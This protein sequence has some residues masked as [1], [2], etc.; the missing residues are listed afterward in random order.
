M[1]KAAQVLSYE[2]E[3]T[4]EA[5][6][7]KIK[8]LEPKRRSYL[9]ST[10]ESFGISSL[11]LVSADTLYRFQHAAKRDFTFVPGAYRYYRASLETA[12]FF[13]AKEN[14]GDFFSMEQKSRNERFLFQ[15]MASFLASLGIRD[16]HGITGEVR[17]SYEKYIRNFY[18]EKLLEYTKYMDRI[19]IESIQASTFT[20]TPH[21]KDEIFY[22]AYYPNIA[23]SNYFY[24]TA[25]KEF[26]F[27]DFSLTVP[28]IL[29]QQI[30]S[31]LINIAENLDGKR[32]HY[33]IQHHITPLWYL[34]RYCI[35]KGIYNLLYITKNEVDDFPLYLKDKMDAISKSA[36]Q[37][38]HRT[39]KF[40]FM[41]TEKIDFESTAWFLERFSLDPARIN[42][43]RPIEAFYFDDIKNPSHRR[44]L[45]S[46]I[47]YLLVLSPKYSL[48]YILSK[49]YDIKHMLHYLDNHNISILG[50]N[51]S[52]LE[53]YIESIDTKDI[54]PE[55]F[56]DT[57]YSIHSFFRNITLRE[58]LTLPHFYFDYYYKKEVPHHNDRSVSEDDIDKILSVL[59]DFPE[60]L[61][62]MYL[63]LYSTG[64]RINEI[65]VIQSDALSISDDTYWLL[66]YQ[67]KMKTEKMIPIPEDLYILLTDYLGRREIDSIYL[68]PSIKD[69]NKPFNAGTFSKQMKQHLKENGITSDIDFR[70]HDYRHTIISDIYYSGAGIQ[71]AREF[72]GHKYEDMTKQYIDHLPGKIDALQKDYFKEN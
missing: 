32:N 47:R 62:L 43:T 20:R 57:L 50:I 14:Y 63:T 55:T 44:Y 30:F 17:I 18:P 49:Y 22:L 42:P 7:L 29:K 31:A 24:Y 54:R 26:L 27:F 69:N 1:P 13:Y 21:Y 36:S 60:H 35:D 15:K 33:T 68:F 48:C 70:S 61:C 53:N 25:R 2:K 40:L 19:K 34:Y 45:Q 67:N 59:S 10:L 65:C 3:N 6:L 58:K 9:L 56:N 5:E 51:S 16:V 72:A 52:I 38:M 46:Y 12:L 11:S 4:L 66:I 8:A 37:V 39:R 41:T 28:R 64:L 71:T 23:I